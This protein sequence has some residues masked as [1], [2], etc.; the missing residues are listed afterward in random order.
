MNFISSALLDIVPFDLGV[1]TDGGIM[2]IVINRCANI[3]INH[4]KKYQLVADKKL[5]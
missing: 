5:K 1:E 3:P 2:S 4:Y